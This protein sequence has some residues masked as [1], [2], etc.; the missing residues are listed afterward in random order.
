MLVVES[1]AAELAKSF[2]QIHFERLSL[3]GSFCAG[4][5]GD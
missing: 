3:T 1:G 4:V 5:V 2:L